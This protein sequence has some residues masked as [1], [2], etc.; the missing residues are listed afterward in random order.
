MD[1]VY[2]IIKDLRNNVIM[3]EEY[4]SPDN[5]NKFVYDS[6][7]KFIKLSESDRY[8]L[9][10]RLDE[11]QSC[12]F[13]GYLI[14]LKDNSEK[15]WRR[16]FPESYKDYINDLITKETLLLNCDE[17]DYYAFQEE[18]DRER[19]LELLT[20]RIDMDGYWDVSYDVNYNYLTNIYKAEFEAFKSDVERKLGCF[21]LDVKT[22]PNLVRTAME[23][24][25]IRLFEKDVEWGYLPD[26]V[27]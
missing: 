11:Y 9:A 3:A 15:K 21:P 23:I 14:T 19:W 20:K 24:W 7:S 5:Y 25:Y 10:A 12:E 26:I 27:E 4:C 2:V 17:S 6:L 13:L 18:E 8:E 1:S 22:E 16:Y